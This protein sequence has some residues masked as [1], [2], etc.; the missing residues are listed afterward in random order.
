MQPSL[1]LNFAMPLEGIYPSRS[2]A[3]GTVAPLSDVNNPLL[4]AVGMFARSTLP[5]SYTPAQGQEISIADNDALYSLIGTTYGGDG[6]QTFGLPDLSGRAPIGVGQGPGLSP[7]LL[8]ELSGTESTTMSLAQMPSHAHTLP[9]TPDMTGETGGGQP[10]LNMQP[11]LGLHYIIAIEG[12]FPVPPD[13][14]TPAIAGVEPLLA[15]ISLFAGDFAPRGW[16]FANGQQLSIAQNTALFALLGTAYGGNG[17]T[18]FALP[19]LRGRIPVGAGQGPGLPFWSL[20]QTDGQEFQTVT[21]DQ[22]APHDHIVPEPT[23][24]VH[25]GSAMVVLAFAARHM[26]RRRAR[27]VA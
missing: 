20:G 22:L 15:E 7:M 23:A 11:S 2:F 9:P 25:A 5:I 12:I 3:A 14:V 6:Q 13:A 18:T 4:S 19:D 24:L 10:L 21:V 1:A 26:A 8:G 16:A 17:V 27:R